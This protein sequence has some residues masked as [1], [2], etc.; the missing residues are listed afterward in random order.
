MKNK[1]FSLLSLSISLALFG[2]NS[3]T[4]TMNSVSS[5]KESVA[6]VLKGKFTNNVYLKLNG[7]V[8]SENI[9]ELHEHDN[10]YLATVK[11]EKGNNYFSVTDNLSGCVNSFGAKSDSLIK[12]GSQTEMMKCGKGNFSLNVVMP[13]FY[14]FTLDY[15]KDVPTLKILRST[16]KVDVKRRPPDIAC[17]KWDLGPITVDVSKAFPNGTLVRDAYSGKT[18]KVKNGKVTMQPSAESEGILLLERALQYTPAQFSWDNANVYFMLTDRFN[19]GDKSNDHSY[20]RKNDGKDE[21]GT[22]HGGDFKGIVEKLDYLKSLNINAIWVTPIVEQVHG[23]VGGGNEG[24]FPFYGYHG[25]WAADFTNIDK[26]LGTEEDFQRFVDE[27]HSRGIRVLVDVVMNHAGYATLKDLQDFDLEELV[28]NEDKLPSDWSDFKP[29]G[30]FATWSSV[31]NYFDRKTKAWKKW[32]GPDWVR[33]GLP[34]Y[35]EGGTDDV[36]G[37]VGGLPDFKTEQRTPVSL[38]YFLKNKKDTKAVE[39]PNYSIVDYL[40]SWH[41]Y[42]V[43]KF[44]I[45]GFRADTV[46]HL[47]PYAWKQLKESAT[48]AL[49]EWKAENPAKKLD[50]LP[51]FMVGEVWDHGVTKDLWYD[52]GFDSLINFDY[53]KEATTYAQCMSQAE[54]V[55]SKYSNVVQDPAFNILSY[56]S[57]HDTKLFFPDYKD[58]GLQKRAANSF[59]MLPGQVQIYYGDESGRELMKDGGWIDQ[60]LRSDMNWKDL[61]KAEVKD[62]VNHWSKLNEFRLNH[63]AIAQGKHTMLSSSPYT[64][65]REKNGD[66]VV[67]VSAGRK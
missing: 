46:K 6:K 60:S 20:G 12:F 8:D 65:K 48:K 30:M 28:Q 58:F 2:C 67:V 37:L 7:K 24:S 43:R 42:Y 27:A 15:T 14:N 41:T 22:W 4:T 62:L 13:G 34:G 49:K 33:A 11:L 19:N 21:I 50:N 64:F 54:E 45:D 39:H 23:F 5:N 35:D 26:N 29:S 31:N 9:F 56:I 3:D 40:V 55:Y 47:D 25:Y 18:A 57:S 32:W 1:L 16:K 44:G 59:L 38:P 66:V 36:F 10:I 51:F 53:Q 63:P 52:N 61:D 17:N